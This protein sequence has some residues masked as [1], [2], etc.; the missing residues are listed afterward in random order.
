MGQG[1]RAIKLG[2]NAGLFLLGADTVPMKPKH[3]CAH[4]GCPELVTDGRYCEQHKKQ[5]IQQQDKRRGTASQRGYNS[6]WRRYSQWFIKQPEN[7]FCKLQ[8][9]GCTNVS[10]CVDHIDPPDGPNDPRFWD[11]NNHQGSCIH[12]NSVKGHGKLIGEGK[13]FEANQRG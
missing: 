10:E 7:V 11:T 3:P 8:L 5:N 6:R 13:P 12:C 1:L 4:P 9:P 2:S